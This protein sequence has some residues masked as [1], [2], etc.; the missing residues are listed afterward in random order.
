MKVTI[1]KRLY[2]GF[3]LMVA[4]ILGV[5]GVA[6]YT[7][8]RSDHLVN[9]F[10][11]KF[12][13]SG[14]AS[15]MQSSLLMARLKLEHFLRNE[16]PEDAAEF[17]EWAGKLRE[18]IEYGKQNFSH[19]ERIELIK[20]LDAKFAIYEGHVQAVL[21]RVAHT[22]KLRTQK[23]DPDLDAVLESIQA[24]VEGA[25]E[26]DAVRDIASIRRAVTRC[27]SAMSDFMESFQVADVESG[28]Q[29]MMEAMAIMDEMVSRYKTGPIATHLKKSDQLFETAS[30][31]Y[32]E[33]AASQLQAIESL[34]KADEL[35]PV[36]RELGT[37]IQE[38]YEQT[39][40]ALDKEAE[41]TMAGAQVMTVGGI[42]IACLVGTVCAVL[43]A[44]STV[45][46]IRS[47][48]DRL[49]DIA[50]GEGDLT[51]RVDENRADELGELGRWFNLFVAKVHDVIVEVS[52][53]ASEVAAA[54]TEI[55]ASNEEM[56]AAVEEVSAQTSQATGTASTAGRVAEE[57]GKV[58]QDTVR[59]IMSLNEAATSSADCVSDLF[60]RSE[61]IGDVI[62]VIRDIADQT[63][64][65]ALNAAIEAARAGEHGRGFAVVADEVRKLAERTGTATEEVSKSITDI[66][67]KTTEAVELM[68][69]SKSLADEGSQSANQAG[70][71]LTTIVTSAREVATLIEQIS[72]ATTEVGASVA[73]SAT[74]STQLST[75]AE[76][77]RSL[78]L[79]FKVQ[80]RSN[81]RATEKASGKQASAAKETAAA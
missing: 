27:D 37:K 66:Q 72:S 73:Q 23:V 60:K 24:A 75:K 68:N 81:G 36:V 58:V 43:I 6:M 71:R 74:A 77:L 19:P 22:T 29:S 55:A 35:G 65:L 41:S 49:K 4:L 16:K 51:Q 54:S 33:L 18:E 21:E 7:T 79:Q 56:A 28:K 52:L 17:S 26:A 1:A 50:Q 12:S 10:V 11:E 30:H 64:L 47:L 59:G 15:A 61:Q 80:P 69:R 42:V 78:V 8:Q 40:V 20:Q 44:R 45:R 48:I 39:A 38:S 13:D 53:S 70:E 62:A 63:N 46:P 5:G 2:G 57:G 31:D 32:F 76:G 14:R 67:T 9:E 34:T 25:T 3:A